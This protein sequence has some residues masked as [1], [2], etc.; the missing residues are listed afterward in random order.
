MKLLSVSFLM[1]AHTLHTSHP[2]QW[3]PQVICPLTAAERSYQR[4][5]VLTWQRTP[6]PACGPALYF[7]PVFPFSLSLSRCLFFH[8]DFKEGKTYRTSVED[9]VTSSCQAADCCPLTS[10]LYFSKCVR[11]CS[12]Y[13]AG[14][15]PRDA[16]WWSPW[17]RTWE[18]NIVHKKKHCETYTLDL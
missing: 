12:H 13:Q 2:Q 4:L 17:R 16:T 14:A 1:H 11:L 18:H 10:A 7:H 5:N 9:L 8:S 3:N 6:G 15:T